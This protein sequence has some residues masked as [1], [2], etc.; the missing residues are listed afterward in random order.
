MSRTSKV[1]L[2]NSY[3]DEWDILYIGW[4]KGKTKHSR[5]I[6]VKL[7]VDFDS[8]DRVVGLEIFDFKEALKKSQEEIDEIFKLSKKNLDGKTFL[9]GWSEPVK[10]KEKKK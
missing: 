5:E 7:V 1:N 3:N 6:N 2:L 10:K 9:G 4:A 8:K